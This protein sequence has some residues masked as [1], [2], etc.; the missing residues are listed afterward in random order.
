M[1]VNLNSPKIPSDSSVPH[2]DV[3]PKGTLSVISISNTN[4]TA[5]E[6]QLSSI[7]SSS[8]S[9]KE[10]SDR[11]SKG[12]SSA[13]I[14]PDNNSALHRIISKMEER[15]PLSVRLSST[16]IYEQASRFVH[17]YPDIL[18]RNDL[19][20][21]S[22]QLYKMYADDTHPDMKALDSTQKEQLVNVLSGIHQKKK[23]GIIP[24]NPH[25]P[26]FELLNS[27]ILARRFN[28]FVSPL[29][30][31]EGS[32]INSRI[33]LALQS[34][35]VKDVLPFLAKMVRDNSYI[36]NSK[37]LSP[38]CQGIRTD[39]FIFY[40]QGADIDKAREIVAQLNDNRTIKEALI[41]HTPMGMK[42]LTPGVSYSEFS[43]IVSV[44]GTLDSSHGRTRSY[45]LASA[46]A[47][48]AKQEDRT[49]PKLYQYIDEEFSRYGYDPKD[50]AL[51]SKKSNGA[52]TQ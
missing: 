8:F 36:E 28:Y 41:D 4:P 29:S 34:S 35:K 15:S 44:G 38:D 27:Y 7:K 23:V 51:L 9:E 50:S 45:I 37:I 21:L 18:S 26:R 25:Y 49:E 31:R 13:S 48:W 17:E 42:S 33:T 39:S 16:S 12:T 24:Q 40:L 6:T 32:E 22:N 5:S 47:K 2:E 43:S 3:I 46:I 11:S 52:R 10:F 1:P 20:L 19:E 30:Y 14:Y